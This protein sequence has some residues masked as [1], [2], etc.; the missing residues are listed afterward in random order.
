MAGRRANSF[1]MLAGQVIGKAG[2]F[3]SLMIYSRIF[4]DA[5]FG[6]LLFAVAVSLILFF[7]SDMGAS[8]LTTRKLVFPEGTAE[9]LSTALFLR[10]AL[11]IASLVLLT[12]FIAVMSYSPDQVKLLY[13]VFGGFV[14]DGYFETFYAL[15]RARDRMVYEGLTRTIQGLLAVV[16][17][18]IVAKLNLSYFWAG[19][20]YPLRSVLPFL[21]CATAAVKI[22]GTGIFKPPSMSRP[23][24]LLRRALPLGLMGLILVAS[25]R[26]DNVLVKSILSDSAVAAWQQCYR[27]FEP[28]VLL[29]APTLL[30]GA[31]FA[32]LC[33]AEASGWHEVKSRIRW[34]TEVFTVLA[35]LIVIPVFFFGTDVLR[36]VWGQEYLRDIPFGQVRDTLRILMMSLPVT[37]V[38]HIYLAVILAQGKQ[39]SILPA[40]LVSFAIQM[41]GLY[42][43]LRVLGLVA[44]A[45]MQLA[46]I[47]ILSVWL[48]LR[49]RAR[50]GSTGFLQG[51]WRPAVSLIPFILSA[52]FLHSRSIAAAVSFA[53]LI[54]VWL[55]AGGGKVLANPP[56]SVST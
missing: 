13:L 21:F 4:S 42:A 49:A 45:G 11:T 41:T 26:F 3:V 40:V 36:T 6:E 15:F 14:L 53:G 54:L 27:I 38:F 30:P 19:A 2:L 29:V 25:Q 48:G 24:V 12:A 5:E 47:L 23:W 7:I 46:F 51:I 34:M 39:K 1:Y 10:S 52:A 22:A 17:A 56:L 44:A 35:F 32:D 18:V 43:G 33:R 9:T 50:H 55:L 37:Y 31:L 8:L 16:I 20:S 28:M